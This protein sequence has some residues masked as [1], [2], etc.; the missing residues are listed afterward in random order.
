MITEKQLKANRR[1]SK[2]GG[3]KSEQG[4]TKSK[5]NSL[6][7]GIFSNE[8]LLNGDFQENLSEFEEIRSNAY[9]T[10]KPEGI[11]EEFCIQ[12][13][14]YG[15]WRMRRVIKAEK[16]IVQSFTNS[17][18]S[19]KE[20]KRAL[21]IKEIYE[22]IPTISEALIESNPKLIQRAIE[23]FQFT[24]NEFERF[25]SLSDILCNRISNYYYRDKNNWACEEFSETNAR[26]NPN[27]EN[28]LFSDSSEEEKTNAKT[29]INDYLDQEIDKLQKG[30]VEVKE[31]T[32]NQDTAN[33]YS[34][35]IP[36]EFD[37]DRLQRYETMLENQIYRATD[38]L[39]KYQALRK[40]KNGFVS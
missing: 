38:E 25:G 23:V 32:N 29:I 35:L 31:Q 30:L 24:K 16:G 6:K 18:I 28:S 10:Y 12:R 7:H 11:I 26:L 22:K 36:N 1:N 3:V 19:E 34:M 9:E 17:F 13:I 21:V 37:M 4:K 33:L 5:M 39:Q 2:L 20:H 27:I 8:I 15:I 40:N 14:I